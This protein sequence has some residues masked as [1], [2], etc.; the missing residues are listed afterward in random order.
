M[1]NNH[2]R[3]NEETTNL[4]LCVNMKLNKAIVNKTNEQSRAKIH[5]IAW[6]LFTHHSMSVEKIHSMV[7]LSMAE[8]I[9]GIHKNQAIKESSQKKEHLAILRDIQAK[10]NLLISK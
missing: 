3:G 2:V 4:L 7:G 9:E 1:E 10:V 8:I 6:N 5:N